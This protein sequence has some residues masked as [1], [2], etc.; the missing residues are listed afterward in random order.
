MAELFTAGQMLSNLSMI[1][2]RDSLEVSSELAAVKWSLRKSSKIDVTRC[3]S[4]SSAP[5]PA[6][7]AY[8]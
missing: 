1:V 7:E 5:T 3:A 4:P 2:L 6:Q 8:W